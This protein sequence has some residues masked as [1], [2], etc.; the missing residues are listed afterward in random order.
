[1]ILASKVP[2]SR[3]KRKMTSHWSRITRLASL[4]TQVKLTRSL[5]DLESLLLKVVRQ[6]SPRLSKSTR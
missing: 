4:A 6:L 5:L 3:R 1:M 2:S